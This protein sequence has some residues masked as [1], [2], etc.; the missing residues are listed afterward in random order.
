[1]TVDGKQGAGAAGAA[2]AAA[3]AKKTA[4][5]LRKKCTVEVV[6]GPEKKEPEKEC[7]E[8]VARWF[9]K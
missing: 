2:A 6:Q 7:S 9:L 1:M 8:D 4:R 3:V 5:G